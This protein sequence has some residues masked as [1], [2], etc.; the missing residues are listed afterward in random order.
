MI[1]NILGV[2]EDMLR[3]IHVTYETNVGDFDGFIAD[4]GWKRQQLTTRANYEGGVMLVNTDDPTDTMFIPFYQY[5]VRL[6]D[7]LLVYD[8]HEINELFV[9]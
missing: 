8:K 5:M 7:D 9:L 6:G 3:M 4:T 2:R 1:Y